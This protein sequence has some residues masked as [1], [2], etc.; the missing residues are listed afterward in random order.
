VKFCHFL[1]K[2]HRYVTKTGTKN[3]KN[4]ASGGQGLF[5]KKPPLSVKHPQ[6]LFI[7]KGKCY[8]LS[9]ILN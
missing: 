9:D 7:K 6:K 1:A 8:N 5:L 2:L 4:L 3:P